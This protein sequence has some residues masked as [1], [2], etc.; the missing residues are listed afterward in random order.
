MEYKLVIAG[1]GGVGKSAITI[2][3][4]QHTFVDVY[5]PTIEDSYRKQVQIGDE[6][7]IL[8]IL[9]TAGQE[10]YSVMR[11]SYYRLGVGFIIVFS[12]TELKSF[13]AVDSFICQIKRIKDTDQ[14]PIVLVGN[15]SDLV[16]ERVITEEQFKEKA[17]SHNIPF[18]ETSASSRI[19]ID[20]T[21]TL[22]VEEI[23]RIENKKKGYHF[24]N[25]SDNKKKKLQC[26]LF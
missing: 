1:S 7:C 26:V 11:D 8:D 22:C 15:K 17:D 9:D 4:I 2:N 23:R 6:V 16:S 3:Y 12:L 13:E 18:L 20:E 10:E 19:N 14:V 24:S 25:K 21:F 5:D